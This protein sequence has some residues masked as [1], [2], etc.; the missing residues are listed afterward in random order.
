M[1]ETKIESKVTSS[2]SS[3]ADVYAVVSNLENL[4]HVSGLIPQDKV[5]DMEF[6][7]DYVR[8]K[9]DGLGQK[10]CIRMVDM[11]ENDYVKFAAEG[12]PMQL[13]FWIQMKQ[14]APEDTRL[15]LTFKGELPMFVQMMLG[16]KLQTGLDQAADMLAQMPFNQWN[17]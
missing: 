17:A 4:K 6:G 8:F 9:V 1:A 7:Q 3:A 15:K 5:S 16:N 2:T 10:V 11:Q 13:N 14:V 12:I